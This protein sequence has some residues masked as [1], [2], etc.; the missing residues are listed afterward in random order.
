MIGGP[1]REVQIVATRA[2]YGQVIGSGFFKLTLNYGNITEANPQVESTTG[3]IPWNA[4]EQEMAAALETLADI[5]LVEVRRYGPGPQNTYEWKITLDWRVIVGAGLPNGGTIAVTGSGTGYGSIGST[6][7]SGFGS[8]AYTFRGPLPLLLAS[9]EELFNVTW[10]GSY[11]TVWTRE[12]RKGS[13]GP[14]LC[15]TYCTHNVTGLL[16]STQYQFRVRAG[17][18]SGWGD[19]SGPSNMIRTL[20]MLPPS[21]PD[22][23]Q[24]LTTTPNSIVLTLVCVCPPPPCGM[25]A[26]LASLPDLPRLSVSLSLSPYLSASPSRCRS[27]SHCVSLSLS[28]C[29]VRS[30]DCICAVCSLFLNVVTAAHSRAS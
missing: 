11:D 22:A 23:P 18:N 9:Y 7:P 25:T 15:D 6:Q 2:D 13:L 14:E 21:T 30:L 3:L 28:V 27:S 10:E 4:T 29:C 24:L 17:S 26:C 20:S 16:P 12:L 5:D 19:W 8:E 1:A